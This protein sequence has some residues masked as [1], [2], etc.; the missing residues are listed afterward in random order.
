MKVNLVVVSPL[1]LPSKPLKNEE[2]GSCCCRITDHQIP[3]Q[4]SNLPMTGLSLIYS[5]LKLL[6]LGLELLVLLGQVDVVL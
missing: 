4:G 6:V 5:L 2:K 1:P 3:P